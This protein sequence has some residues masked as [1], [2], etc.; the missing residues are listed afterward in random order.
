MS[1]EAVL[2]IG[3]IV[4][5]LIGMYFGFAHGVKKGSSITIDVLIKNNL[6]KW[7]RVNGDIELLKLDQ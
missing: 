4:G 7:R 6:V 3:Y 1:V 2:I 5:T